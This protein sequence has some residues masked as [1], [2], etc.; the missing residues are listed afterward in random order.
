VGN[1]RMGSLVWTSPSALKFQIN[2]VDV[3][4]V[5]GGSDS[6]IREKSTGGRKMKALTCLIIMAVAVL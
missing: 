3:F 1:G 2:R 4:S 6:V 5:D